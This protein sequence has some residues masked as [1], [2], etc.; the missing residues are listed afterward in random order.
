MDW[1]ELEDDAY[2]DVAL[3][4]G[5]S[6]FVELQV[7]PDS[8]FTVMKN[9]SDV[10][11][12][13]ATWYK[14]VVKIGDRP[15]QTS[16]EDLSVESSS[17]ETEVD[18][19]ETQGDLYSAD[20]IDESEAKSEV[21]SVASSTR[22]SVTVRPSTRTTKSSKIPIRKS[23]LDGAFDDLDL[24][25]DIPPSPTLSSEDSLPWHS[26]KD[27]EDYMEENGQTGV[28][29]DDLF[30]EL[31]DIYQPFLRVEKN[32]DI[33]LHAAREVEPGFYRVEVAFYRR[34]TKDD[35]G[36]WVVDLCDVIETCPPI[37]GK[38]VFNLQKHTSLATQII[39]PDDLHDVEDSEE[40]SFDPREKPYLSFWAWTH[41]TYLQFWGER[42]VDETYYDDL[43]A[44][45]AYLDSDELVDYVELM[46]KT[47]DDDDDVFL[48]TPN[49]P[50]SPSKSKHY[51]SL[52]AE[53][54]EDDTI[55][56]DVTGLDVEDVV[57]S[58]EEGS[59]MSPVEEEGLSEDDITVLKVD[60]VMSGSE[61]CPT[62]PISDD[63]EEEYEG[64]EGDDVVWEDDPIPN[65][66]NDFFDSE[67]LSMSS[68]FEEE[69]LNMLLEN[70]TTLNNDNAMSSSEE[71][72]MTS[73][74]KEKAEDTILEDITAVHVENVASDPE[75]RFLTSPVEE[76]VEEM[77]PEDATA[78][79]VD[80]VVRESD[81]DELRFGGPFHPP[82]E[83]V[84]DFAQ[85]MEWYEKYRA[86]R[87]A[88]AEFR[89]RVIFFLHRIL[90]VLFVLILTIC[91]CINGP[92]VTIST[93]KNTL[94]TVKYYANHLGGVGYSALKNVRVSFPDFRL[95]EREWFVRET[96]IPTTSPSS[97]EEDFN[98]VEEYFLWKRV[99]ETLERA[100]ITD[101]P[102]VFE[103][104][105]PTA[106]VL[107]S[108]LDAE[109]SPSPPE[110]A[111][112]VTISVS[113]ATIST[114]E[115]A[116][117][118]AMP[119]NP[120]ITSTL[121]HPT[122]PTQTSSAVLSLAIKEDVFPRLCPSRCNPNN[123]NRPSN[124]PLPPPHEPAIDIL[125]GW[126][127]GVFRHIACS[128]SPM[129]TI[130]RISDKYEQPRDIF[131]RFRCDGKGGWK[132]DTRRDG[133][134]RFWGW[135]PDDCKIGV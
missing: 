69:V 80:N 124:C 56:E 111:S 33:V 4:L 101:C 93:P 115:P 96:A 102:A 104:A 114:P 51:M 130:A 37:P 26:T 88:Q 119:L 24:E 57:C 72:P 81:E 9:A 58:P 83:P 95:S 103:S 16:V 3:P 50:E 79:N 17:L 32:G 73:A 30:T 92:P 85:T 126:A 6:V 45:N 77:A 100:G 113:T 123:P 7:E 46:Y 82:P 99:D 91:A 116:L 106:E 105:E 121:D 19:F 78:P 29:I 76:K 23:G 71:G 48:E 25:L 90:P 38:M 108:P 107:P 13:E 94:H 109:T 75:K 31:D 14:G 10:I 1:F 97:E 5:V 12:M 125:A 40:A 127:K 49:T 20:D 59:D 15:P 28:D 70:L 128:T 41:A 66:D 47:R 63:E 55:R 8:V 42:E 133:F 2:P 44:P 118:I 27:A 65:V 60:N 122:T 43:I 36:W 120:E 135:T 35:Q 62:N 64:E 129:C 18:Q 54:E 86:M 112:E 134:D 67:E 39:G 53:E 34:F 117:D 21:E 98:D 11:N 68:S 89:R 52:I 22:S 84:P 132:P 87:T 74:V 131:A 110:L 61:E